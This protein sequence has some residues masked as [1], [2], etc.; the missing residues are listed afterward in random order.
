MFREQIQKMRIGT[1]RPA[2]LAKVRIQ[3]FGIDQTCI[4]PG[5]PDGPG[6][7]CAKGAHQFGIH[8][9]GEY[10]EHGVD[11]F[12]GRDPEAVYETTLDATF[13]EKARHLF[14]AAVHN[15]SPISGIRAYS[16]D[17]TGEPHP[18]ISGIEQSS[19]QFDQELTGIHLS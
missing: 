16:G 11:D 18:G 15:D 19:A 2:D 13:G 4:Q 12:R 9:P 3:Q 10:F 8:A 17:F 1:D 5:Q 6:S 7:R 14:A